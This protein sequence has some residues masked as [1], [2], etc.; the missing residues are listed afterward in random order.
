MP[1][2]RE[3]SRTKMMRSILSLGFAQLDAGGT[4]AVNLRAV[5][6]EL[7]VV[8]SALYRYVRNR[9][10]LLTLLIEDAFGQLADAVQHEDPGSLP[11]LAQAMRRWALSHPQRWALI[12]GSPIAGYFAPERT[13]DQGTRVMRMMIEQLAA[14][15]PSAPQTSASRA[16]LSDLSAIQ[17]EWAPALDLAVI[18]LALDGWTHLIGLIS[19][20]VFGQLGRDTLSEPEEFFTRAVERLAASLGLPA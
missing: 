14:A 16:L 5:A 10:E 13:I 12:Y 2:P 20:E 1:S 8:S 15:S 9:D 6:R 19:A 7:G 17:R 11:D 4:E 18:E 3:L